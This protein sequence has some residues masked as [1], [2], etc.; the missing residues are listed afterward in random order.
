MDSPNQKEFTFD[1]IKAA[2]LD[3][4]A[5]FPA[6]MVYFFSDIS[7]KDLRSLKRY[8]RRS[9]LTAG[10]GCWKIW[11]PCPRPIPCYSSTMLP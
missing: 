9:G 4:A 7:A 1:E 6:Q 5:P 11:K 8:G 10:V 3:N 2:L